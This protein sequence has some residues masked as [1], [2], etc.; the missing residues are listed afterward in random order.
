MSLTHGGQDVP[1]VVFA[2]DPVSVLVD[3]CESLRERPVLFTAV[4]FGG[5][6]DLLVH[7][8]R[9]SLDHSCLSSS[10]SPVT[11]GELK[12]ALLSA[13]VDISHHHVSL[14]LIRAP[15]EP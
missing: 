10:D 9:L 14:F 5:G 2:D 15:A 1:Q 11:A 8:G 4:A 7:A 12:T 3:D 13:V 6:C